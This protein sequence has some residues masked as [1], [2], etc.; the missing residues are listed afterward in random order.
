MKFDCIIMNPPY[1]RNLHLM[2][3][4]E[5]IK[6]LK[7]EKSV[8]VNFSPVRWLQDPLAKYKKKCDLKRF[9]DSVAKH[10]ESLKIVDKI[11]ALQMFDA[12][13]T[14]NL[15]IYKC[16]SNKS[17]YDYLA[18][19]A[20]S[21]VTKVM[22]KMQTSIADKVEY[23]KLNG[24]RVR[25]N[26]IQPLEAC[27]KRDPSTQS[28][29]HFL[30]N[31]NT[32]TY[33]YNNGYTK[34]GVFWTDLVQKGKYTKNKGDPLVLSIPFSTEQEAFNFEAFCKTTFM[35]ALK[36]LTQQD[37]NVPLFAFPF[38]G[39]AINP[40]TGLKGYTGEWTDDDLALYFGI[41]P[42]EQKVIEETMEKY[43]AK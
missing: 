35:N 22:S 17:N 2:I 25:V 38:L 7:D 31:P 4:A 27:D 11:S 12:G 16:V 19:S 24:W 39:N 43:A 33:V 15:G 9:E 23:N 29:R 34:D 21:I 8:C 41:T 5:A 20:N 40:R 37:I 32:P 18:I 28:W 10:I 14:M 36:N 42:D 3:L 26:A 6:H 1:V 30:V 13:F